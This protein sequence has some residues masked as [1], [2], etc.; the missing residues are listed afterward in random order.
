VVEATTGTKDNLAIT[1]PSASVLRVTDLPSGAYT[2]SGV[3][4]GSGCTRSGDNA[5]NCSGNIA[6]I[7]VLS[8]DQA[9]RVSNTTIVPSNLYGG[10][11]DDTLSGGPSS[12]M[13]TGGAGADVM[14]GMNGNDQL[15]ARDLTSDTTINCDG[16]TTSGGA[17]KAD[18]DLLPKDPTSAVTNCETKTRH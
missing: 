9:D 13:L 8:G 18:L 14:K 3:H 11:G 5:A 4:T 6:R 1:R 16:G 2:G 7:R 10:D 17:D 12:D 15:F